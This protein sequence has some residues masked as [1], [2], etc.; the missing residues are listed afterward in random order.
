MVD[1]AR[2]GRNPELMLATTMITYVLDRFHNLTFLLKM[3]DI[4]TPYQ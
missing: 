4:T 3:M 2:I 1:P